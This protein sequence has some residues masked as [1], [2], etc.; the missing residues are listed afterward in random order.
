[1][2]NRNPT[3]MRSKLDSVEKKSSAIPQQVSPQLLGLPIGS[4]IGGLDFSITNSSL[5]RCYW[6]SM[7]HHRPTENPRVFT[8]IGP[9]QRLQSLKPGNLLAILLVPSCRGP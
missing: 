2:S 4:I 6:L 1:M 5:A 3:R 9:L 8:Q 7:Y